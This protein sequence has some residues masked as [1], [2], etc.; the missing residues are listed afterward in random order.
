ML[1]LEWVVDNKPIGGKVQ[2]TRL[3]FCPV[4]CKLW[5][6]VAG[7][8]R[9]KVY[10]ILGLVDPREAE[11]VEPDYSVPWETVFAKATFASI[12][13][14]NSIEILEQLNNPGA[15]RPS[16]LPSW[17]RSG[18]SRIPPTMASSLHPPSV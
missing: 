18:P 14:Q 7:D 1:E 16:R 17:V 8:P 9:D 12:S 13:V 11:M 6:P 3:G 2:T 10:S 15:S 4:F 5:D